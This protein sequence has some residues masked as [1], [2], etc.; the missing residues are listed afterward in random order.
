MLLLEIKTVLEQ[1]GQMT[2]SDLA[3]HF[4][5][6]ES[7]MQSMLDQWYKK[8]RLDIIE[9]SGLC[10]SAC[11]QCAESNKTSVIYR[12]KK[13]TQKPIHTQTS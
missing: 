11:G 10:G 2:L 13:I 12:W 7:L 5:V 3:N 1:R 4:Y 9:T 8:G 6:S